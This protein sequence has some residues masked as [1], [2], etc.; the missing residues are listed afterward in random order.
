M[1]QNDWRAAALHFG[2]G[3]TTFEI[4]V[5]PTCPFS[6]KAMAKLEALLAAVGEDKLTI[7]L[8]LN[9][10]PWHLW[11]GIVTRCVIAASTLADGRDRAW[12]V[13]RA[14]ADHREEFVFENHATGPNRQATPDQIIERIERYSGVELVAAFDNPELDTVTKWHCRYAR[15]NGIHVT[16][17]FMING[18]VDPDLGSGDDVDRWAE[19]IRAA[20]E[21]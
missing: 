21:R 8:R 6:T 12:E 10:Q 17:T 14:V 3:P 4:F 13:L 16:P 1:N 18:L 5:E 7:K 19:A 20:G 9:P 15:Q 2:H 11:S